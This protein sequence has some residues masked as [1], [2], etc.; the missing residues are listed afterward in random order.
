MSE[1]PQPMT[2]SGFFLFDPASRSFLS[3]ADSRNAALSEAATPVLG[4]PRSIISRRR[5][6]LTCPGTVVLQP[7]T[8]FALDS[9]ELFSLG[10][11]LPWPLQVHELAKRPVSLR[12]CRGTVYSRLQIENTSAPSPFGRCRPPTTV[13]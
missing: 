3:R 4:R 13:E 10:F 8:A 1:P 6:L 2:T 12:P 5:S 11:S 7:L 9:L